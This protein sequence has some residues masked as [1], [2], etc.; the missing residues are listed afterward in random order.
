MRIFVCCIFSFFVFVSSVQAFLGDIVG[1]AVQ[2]AVNT[3]VKEQIKNELTSEESKEMKRA[4]EN[5]TSLDINYENIEKWVKENIS[6]TQWH[7]KDDVE[8]ETIADDYDR[9]GN[10]IRM[11]AMSCEHGIV[12]VK[13][14]VDQSQWTDLVRSQVMM[15]AAGNM[16]EDEA[17]DTVFDIYVAKPYILYFSCAREHE[18]K[19]TESFKGLFTNMVKMEMSFADIF[20]Q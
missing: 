9:D 15:S 11:K 14:C 5:Q 4:I 18:E 8:E 3:A 1:N 13:Y 12:T 20:L 7:S 6:Y 19:L 17:D 16:T 10:K 2:G